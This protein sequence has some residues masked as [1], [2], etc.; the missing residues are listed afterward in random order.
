MRLKGV[1]GETKWNRP[2]GSQMLS[3]PALPEERN[4]GGIDR[5]QYFVSLR[6]SG[7]PNKH[8]HIIGVTEIP[9]EESFTRESW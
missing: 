8:E 4:E 2:E 9:T 3:T 7:G 1:V 5:S 6:V